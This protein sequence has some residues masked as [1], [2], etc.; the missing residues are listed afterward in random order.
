MIYVQFER[1]TITL[2]V[3]VS[4]KTRYDVQWKKTVCVYYYRKIWATLRFVRF[5]MCVE[6]KNRLS[7]EFCTFMFD[8]YIYCA[9]KHILLDCN[10]VYCFWN[11]T[12]NRA[13]VFRV[14]YLIKKMKKGRTQEKKIYIYIYKKKLYH[15]ER[16]F[17]F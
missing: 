11:A 15:V 8:R 7:A 9:V 5:S 2:S 3:K 17:L 14:F 12:I 4:M 13:K 10:I 16:Y 6:M 1:I